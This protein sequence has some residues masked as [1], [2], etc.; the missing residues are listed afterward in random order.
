[1]SRHAERSLAVASNSHQKKKTKITHE[2][3]IEARR[4][5]RLA[6]RSLARSLGET[7]G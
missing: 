6:V 4:P 2:V 3:L 1:M 5:G 7:K